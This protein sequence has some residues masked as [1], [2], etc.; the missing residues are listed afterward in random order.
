MAKKEKNSNSSTS[1]GGSDGGG[2][3][4]NNGDGNSDNSNDNDN[5]DNRPTGPS[6]EDNKDLV[7][8]NDHNNDIKCNTCNADP[9]PTHV[10]DGSC[11]PGFSENP[12]VNKLNLDNKPRCLI[13]EGCG[14]GSIKHPGPGPKPSPINIIIN[15]KTIIHKSGNHHS[16]SGLSKD[17]I[18]VVRLVWM[19]NIHR[20]QDSQVD[21]YIG[22]C[23]AA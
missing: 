2:S 10:C 17:C 12:D 15:I 9:D 5:G 3:S 18:D 16:S 11:T 22:R 1:D 21:E 4:D 20:G 23:L 14:P 7:D 8:D 6:K 19:G 13:P